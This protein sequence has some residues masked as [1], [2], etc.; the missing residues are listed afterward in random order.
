MNGDLMHI[1]I[2]ILVGQ[3]LFVNGGN[4][5]VSRRDAG[6]NVS[7]AQRKSSRL[8]FHALQIQKIRCHWP[9]DCFGF[10]LFRIDMHGMKMHVTFTYCTSILFQFLY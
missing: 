2:M 8:V 5:Q 10:G 9:V 3:D 6:A 4:G 1:D 7:D